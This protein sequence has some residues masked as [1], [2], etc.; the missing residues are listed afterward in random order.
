MSEERA[1]INTEEK[2]SN[3][4]GEMHLGRIDTSIS[5][6]GFLDLLSSDIDLSGFEAP[7]EHVSLSD[8][9]KKACDGLA[10][11]QDT[12][13]NNQPAS[14]IDEVVQTRLPCPSTPMNEAPNE[15]LIMGL[16]GDRS[17]RAAADTLSTGLDNQEAKTDKGADLAASLALRGSPDVPPEEGDE[18]SKK[19][20]YEEDQKRK[21]EGIDQWI[22]DEFH[23]YVELI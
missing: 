19:R 5:P 17:A 23:E 1:P 14:F 4:K 10:V 9:D 12:S 18:E 6:R 13:E 3:T 7:L 16:D 2:E 8:L 20:A 15:A 11:R 22:Y 21:W